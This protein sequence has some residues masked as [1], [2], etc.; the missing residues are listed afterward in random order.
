VLKILLWKW[1][2]KNTKFEYTSEHVNLA[3]EQLRD[4]T[5]IPLRFACVTDDPVGINEDIEILPLP[6]DFMSVRSNDWS[7]ALGKPQCFIRLAMYSP[8]AEYT[9]GAKRFASIDLDFKVLGNMDDIFSR[10]E[11]FIIAQ[12]G[13]P[14]IRPYNGSLQMLTAGARPQVY[15]QFT[16]EEYEK[17][18]HRWVGSDQ[19]WISHCLGD[20]EATWKPIDGVYFCSPG[21]WIK[22]YKKKVPSNAKIVFFAGDNAGKPIGNVEYLES[23]LPSTQKHSPKKSRQR[24]RTQAQ[25]I[26]AAKQNDTGKPRVLLYVPTKGWS[27]DFSGQEVAKRLDCFDWQFVYSEKELLSYIKNP[28]LFDLVYF[29]SDVGSAFDAL[30]RYPLLKNK[31]VMTITTGGRMLPDRLQRVMSAGGFYALIAQNQ[32]TMDKISNRCKAKLLP[33]GVDIDMFSPADLPD[34]FTAGFAGRNS[35]RQASQ[36]KGYG[37]LVKPACDKAGV[38]LLACG[39]KAGRLPREQMPGFYNS[40]NILVQP[41][42]SEGCSNTINEAMACGRICMIL[43]GVGYHGEVCVGDMD[44]PGANVVF[45]KRDVNDIAEKITYIRNNPVIYRRISR[46]ARLFAVEHSWDVVIKDYKA[47]LKGAISEARG[48]RR[49]HLGLVFDETNW[50]LGEQVR[51]DLAD[52]C[53]VEL[54]KRPNNF[55]D[56]NTL[57]YDLLYFY[58]HQWVRPYY[59]KQDIIT[60]VWVDG[61]INPNKYQGCRAVHFYDK[62]LQP[63]TDFIREHLGE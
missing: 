2:Q 19:R 52:V 56:I 4:N 33:N 44:D 62:T 54:L 5:T 50:C 61:E 1:K 51:D 63:I 24:D 15:T 8:W 45:V 57:G 12:S 43:S 10:T 38:P 48:D 17:A 21:K 25:T 37:L 30:R 29:R 28:S 7:E 53:C 14:A 23:L 18:P 20:K 32:E 26:V 13:N 36:Q 47:F 39:D 22:G 9:F 6:Y 35:S 34:T 11:D 59:R 40:I 58:D 49:K 41:S 16:K 31:C 46:N 60:S 27:F 42:H 55:R 3:V